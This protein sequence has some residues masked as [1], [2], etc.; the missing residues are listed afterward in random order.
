MFKYTFYSNSGWLSLC[1]YIDIVILMHRAFLI[2]RF[3]SHMQ[4]HRNTPNASFDKIMFVTG[5]HTSIKSYSIQHIIIHQKVV[6]P[7][8]LKVLLM[9]QIK[10]VDPYWI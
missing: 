10:F 9:P 2:T 1:G 8:I 6:A 3:G 4:P 5:I 7:Q